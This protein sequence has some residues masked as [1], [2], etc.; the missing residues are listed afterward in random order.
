MHL[1]RGGLQTNSQAIH[2]SLQVS[3]DTV[4]RHVSS[5]ESP[6][7]HSVSSHLL[8]R[9]LGTLT[10]L[11]SVVRSW[12]KGEEV[13]PHALEP[14]V[15]DL[16]SWK[17]FKGRG[18]GSYSF[19][20]EPGRD[21][22]QR[23]GYPVMSSEDEAAERKK[24]KAADNRRLI[25]A[26]FGSVG[27]FEKKLEMQDDV[28]I[29]SHLKVELDEDGE[30]EQLRFVHVDELE[31]IGCTYCADVAR[32]TF[33]MEDEAGRARVFS[34][35]TDSPEVVAEA[36]D[37]CPVNCISYVSFEDLRILEMEREG[38]FGDEGQIISQ[39]QSGIRGVGDSYVNRA[40][41]SR[42]SRPGLQCENCPMK[43][44]R[45]CPQYGVGQNPVYLER[46]KAREEKKAKS[47][48]A[49]LEAEDAKKAKIVDEMFKEKEQ[50]T[51]QWVDD[52]MLDGDRDLIDSS[53]D[54]LDNINK[55]LWYVPEDDSSEGPDSPVS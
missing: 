16:N 49:A 26:L 9:P 30:P 36:I 10:K 2:E 44:C 41:D 38:L 19:E 43:G 51:L 53:E 28:T 21:R 17:R 12:S 4:S 8:L 40:F 37:C 52:M 22:A 42:A 3:S 46:L 45:D 25:D 33:F 27:E 24:Q 55:A 13:R 54:N 15:E 32:N 47:G 35:G 7:N 5:G 29:P 50:D 14:K 48:Q 20:Q 11:P 39:R 23:G 34:Q 18:F 31:C 1:A 6:Q